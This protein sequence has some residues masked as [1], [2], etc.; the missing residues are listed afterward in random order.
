MSRPFKLKKGKDLKDFF[1]SATKTPNPTT[2]AVRKKLDKKEDQVIESMSNARDNNFDGHMEMEIN[3]SK[4]YEK[5]SDL[6]KHDDDRL[7]L[8]PSFPATP[9][10]SRQRSDAEKAQEA[11]ED[12]EGK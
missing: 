2:K 7:R 5:Y 9:E 8:K 3:K 10:G 1:K 11:K 6:E 4:N 12:A